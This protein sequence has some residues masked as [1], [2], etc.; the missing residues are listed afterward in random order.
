LWSLLEGDSLLLIEEPE[1]SLHKAVVEQIP[2]LIDRV[3]RQ[4]KYRRQIIISTHSEAMLDNP[5]IDAKGIVILEPSR[6]GTIVRPVNAAEAK[7]LEAGLSVADVV[8]PQTRPKGVE[9]L[10]LW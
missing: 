9:Q 3:Q 2:M 6:E 4:A 8:L 10:G 5:G 7:G 1:L